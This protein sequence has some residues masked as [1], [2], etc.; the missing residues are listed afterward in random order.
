MAGPNEFSDQVCFIWA[1]IE[2]ILTDWDVGW[3]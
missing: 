1:V 2:S 3:L